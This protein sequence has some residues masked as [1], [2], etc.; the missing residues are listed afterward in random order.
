MATVFQWWPP[1]AASELSSSGH[2]PHYGWTGEGEIAQRNSRRKN[3][4]WLIWR[5]TSK[6]TAR[7]MMRRV[8]CI[9]EL[10]NP[11]IWDDR[12]RDRRPY[13]VVNHQAEL[14]LGMS[15]AAETQSYNMSPW[16]Y[17]RAEGARQRI[18]ALSSRV[19]S[20]AHTGTRTPRPI[21]V[22]VLSAVAHAAPASSAAAALRGIQIEFEAAPVPPMRIHLGRGPRGPRGMCVQVR[23]CG[24]Q[25]H[26]NWKSDTSS[27]SVPPV[28]MPD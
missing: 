16:T 14:D 4:S 18:G 11:G 1:V 19:Q 6:P 24:C 10:E 7:E 9:W 20:V 2:S 28:L 12:R 27:R 8:E 15:Q 5:I 21:P 17:S 13:D 3:P 23:V 25:Q 22:K 26:S